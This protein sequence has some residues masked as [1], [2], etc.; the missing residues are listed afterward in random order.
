MAQY[1]VAP[2]V[3]TVRSASDRNILTHYLVLAFN[4]GISGLQARGIL[5]SQN[6]LC[7][8]LRPEHERRIQEARRK[9]Q[10]DECER[11][12]KEI[13]QYEMILR[14]RKAKELLAG[15]YDPQTGEAAEVS[16][17]NDNGNLV[18][19]VRGTEWV[20]SEAQRLLASFAEQ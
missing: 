17:E 20:R 4:D 19:A 11:L 8:D 16:F 2:I 14:I 15:L 7:P 9:Q 5:N 3:K 12:E 6:E 10:A 13:A 18:V 1:S